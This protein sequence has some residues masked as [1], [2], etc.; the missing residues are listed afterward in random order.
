MAKEV[1]FGRLSEFEQ[2]KRVKDKTKSV[3]SDR[4]DI[5]ENCLENQDMNPVLINHLNQNTKNNPKA[6]IPDGKYPLKVVVNNYFT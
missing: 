6:T 2:L 5:I 4:K 3:C 1:D